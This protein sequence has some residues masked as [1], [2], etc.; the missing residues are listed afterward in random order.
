MKDG[1][2]APQVSIIALH[3]YCWFDSINFYLCFHTSEFSFRL[4]H[5]ALASRLVNEVRHR[6]MMTLVL[7]DSPL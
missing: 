6:S 5:P 1:H 4:F 3:K 2:R 7:I